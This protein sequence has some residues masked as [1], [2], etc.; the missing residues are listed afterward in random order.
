MTPRL[1][2]SSKNIVGKKQGDGRAPLGFKSHWNGGAKTMATARDNF[3][4]SKSRL[5]CA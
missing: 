5:N 1:S 4:F 2:L 3:P